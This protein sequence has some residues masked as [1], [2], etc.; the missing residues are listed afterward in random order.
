M[1]RITNALKICWWAFINPKTM[2]HSTFKMASDILVMIMKVAS[3]DR[4]RMTHIA[5]IHP[6]DN[7][8]HQ[9]VSIWAGAGIAADPLKRIAELIE[10]NRRLKLLIAEEIKK[11]SA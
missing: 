1:K 5:F 3:E 2:Q 4:H 6:E 7:K 8:E 10:E 9:I 11:K